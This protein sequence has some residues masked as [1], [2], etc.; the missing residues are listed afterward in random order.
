MLANG[1]AARG[2][3][4]LDNYEF[5]A[6]ADGRIDLRPR[7][8]DTLL[9]AGSALVSEADGELL[10]VHGRLTKN[11]SFWTRN[12]D[13]RRRYARINGVRVPIAMESTAHVRLA[14]Q[15]QFAMTYRYLE[16]N[17]PAVDGHAPAG[18]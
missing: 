2:G 18:L 8:Q 11:P 12:G 16:V 3:L 10:D 6:G 1:Q 9:V 7:R 14:G 4:T 5:V 17:G 15:S 13:V